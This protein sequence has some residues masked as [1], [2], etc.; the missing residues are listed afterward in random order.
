MNIT[1]IMKKRRIKIKHLCSCTGLSE[2]QVLEALQEDKE[3][4]LSDE[5]KIVLLKGICVVE[6]HRNLLINLTLKQEEHSNSLLI[7]ALRG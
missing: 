7:K 6:A 4:T 2:K 1:E 3:E 5:K